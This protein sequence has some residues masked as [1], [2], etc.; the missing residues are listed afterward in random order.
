MKCCMK[1]VMSRKMRV[2]RNS[3]VEPNTEVRKAW[4]HYR[5]I[6][7]KLLHK[8]ENNNLD[9]QKKNLNQRLCLN[10][11]WS[12]THSRTGLLGQYL[13]LS[14]PAG[15][16]GILE[17]SLLIHAFVTSAGERDPWSVWSVRCF[18]NWGRGEGTHWT[19]GL[20]GPVQFWPFLWNRKTIPGHPARRIVT[21]STMLS[22][23]YLE[24][25][26]TK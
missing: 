26:Q 19:G 5:S 15:H 7:K 9:T 14:C 18:N 21:I 11:L 12:S 16:A 25:Q 24:L 6:S 17:V 23:Q 3:L 20:V 10:D 22:Q 8:Y 13:N 2:E 4:D 1:V